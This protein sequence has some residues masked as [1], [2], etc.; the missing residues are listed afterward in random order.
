MSPGP[1]KIV[2]VAGKDTVDVPE[3]FRSCGLPYP[4]VPG[5]FFPPLVLLPLPR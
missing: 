3:L 2:G 1:D 5:R 4:T